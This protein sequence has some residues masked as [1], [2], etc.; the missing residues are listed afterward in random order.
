M[1]HYLHWPDDWGAEAAAQLRRVQAQVQLLLTADDF[2]RMEG[3]LFRLANRGVYLELCL[4]EHSSER[5]LRHVNARRRLALAGAEVS[6]LP[7]TALDDDPERF[8]IFDRRH[9]LSNTR[10]EPADDHRALLLEKSRQFRALMAAGRREDPAADG[11]AIRLWSSLAEVAPGDTVDIHWEVGN[12]D[13]VE[14]DPGIGP[15]APVGSL[16]VP[17]HRDTLFRIKAGNREGIRMRS[18]IVR[19]TQPALLELTLSVVD[20]VGGFQIPLESASAVGRS[21]ALLKGDLLRIEW[22]APAS[23][24]LSEPTLGPLPA[25]GHRDVRVSGDAIFVFTLATPR[26]EERTAVEVVAMDEPSALAFRPALQPPRVQSLPALRRSGFISA[27]LRRC[28]NLF[29]RR[30]S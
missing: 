23:A 8:A 4:R 7:R 17:I 1:F 26:G 30:D 22:R 24:A 3:E 25:E 28:R 10:Y 18:L 19:L 6:V 12:A 27:L 11:V 16:S 9:L 5:G 13:F 14:M 21:Y 2:G 29:R 20:P 15:V